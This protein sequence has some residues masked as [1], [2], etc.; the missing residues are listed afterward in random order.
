MEKTGLKRRTPYQRLWG[1][2]EK[3]TPP[4]SNYKKLFL[5]LVIILL[6]AGLF[7]FMSFL[8]GYSSAKRV[9]FT[10][11]HGEQVLREGAE[12]VEISM[13]MRRGFKTAFPAYAAF[14]IGIGVAQLV[15]FWRESRS[16]YLMKRL[17]KD[18][19]LRR[20]FALPLIALLLGAA[21]AVLLANLCVAI[22]V[23]QTPPQALP[24]QV[25]LWSYDYL[26]FVK[27]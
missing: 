9:L 14:C 17:P 15:S 1:F 12:I 18:E 4:G 6:I 21:L 22:Y 27:R 2:L 13:L 26:I 25:R 24:E 23:H 11:Y 5:Q 19:V 20:S 8:A 3:N 16:I 10:W 7:A